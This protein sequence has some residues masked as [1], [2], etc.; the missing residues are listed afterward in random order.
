[1]GYFDC[2]RSMKGNQEIKLYSPLP[3]WMIFVLP[4]VLNIF[5]H[6]LWVSIGLY[7]LGIFLFVIF[8]RRSNHIWRLRSYAFNLLLL[9][10]TLASYHI[11]PEYH[12]FWSLVA[13]LLSCV[14][15][16]GL[17]V[18]LSQ[19]GV[20]Q[21][22]PI[23]LTS[24]LFM[25]SSLVYLFLFAIVGLLGYEHSLL[26]KA[27]LPMALIIIVGAY[28]GYILY[29]RKEE[30]RQFTCPRG[31]ALVRMAIVRN[32]EVWLTDRPYTGCFIDQD[33]E[34]SVGRRCGCCKN[35]DQPITSCVHDGETPEDALE[36]AIKESQLE[37][38]V[39]PRHLLKYRY[40]NE[41]NQREVH[42]FVINIRP[43]EGALMLALKG[44][45]YSPYEVEELIKLGT[46]SDLFIQE[47]NYLKQTLFPANAL[48]KAHH[49]QSVAH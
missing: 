19:S 10:S 25:H 38:K 35:T 41:H 13:L 26:T 39:A 29:S 24:A 14:W 3:A 7:A 33:I 36:R 21:Y 49:E 9:L 44:R 15:R 42:L 1:M 2:F 31:S 20:P 32:D 6:S 8:T 16:W 18:Y 45:Y 27:Y 11:L 47:Y 30:L 22:R 37:S 4:F 34:S 5:Q 40:E 48:V 46:F 28:S 43:K 12:T 17:N 23:V